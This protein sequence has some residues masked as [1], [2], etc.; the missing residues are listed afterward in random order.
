MFR[1]YT[2]AAM[3]FAALATGVV[4]SWLDAANRDQPKERTAQDIAKDWA[5]KTGRGQERHFLNAS[6]KDSTKLY[7][8]NGRLKGVSYA[9]AWNFY[10][11]K[12]G[13]DL[14]Y[15]E[16]EIHVTG[17]EVKGG[18]Y[19]IVDYAF[20]QAKRSTTFAFRTDEYNVS[21]YLQLLPEEEGV[22]CSITVTTH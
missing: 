9:D 16:K 11:A 6:P 3:T 7:A 15:A 10:A 5:Y 14:K 22:A 4:P 20:G 21:V 18:Q 1:Y 8:A 12:C 13:A 19:T 2:V 17:K